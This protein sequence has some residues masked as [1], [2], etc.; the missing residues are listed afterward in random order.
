MSQP[1]LLNH[2]VSILDTA[3]I[4]F[5]VTGSI[6]SSLQGEP[7]S[8]HDVDLIA[9]LSFSQGEALLAAF[10]APDYYLAESSVRDA[11]QRGSIFNLLANK[12]GDKVVFWMLK[13]DPFDR[14]RFARRTKIDFEGTALN[15]STPEDTILAKFVWSKLSG[16]SEK[17]F[18]DAL[19]VYELQF[20]NLDLA[21]LDSWARDLG[22]S[23]LMERLKT[24]AEPLS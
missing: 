1:E 20:A 16:G 10:S 7:R 23:D 13:P 21:Y 19:R 4:E 22:V 24:A 12:Q 5:M 3:G 6:V 18:H 15:V 14:S 9:N 8:T 17:Q 2:V 11:I